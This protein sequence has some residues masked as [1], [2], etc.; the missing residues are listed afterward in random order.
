[1]GLVL[2][3][4]DGH[5]WTIK[6][7]KVEFKLFLNPKCL[8]KFISFCSAYYWCKFSDLNFLKISKINV[9]TMNVVKDGD[10]T[11]PSISFSMIPPL[12]TFTQFYFTQKI[13]SMRSS[14]RFLAIFSHIFTTSGQVSTT[15]GHS[16]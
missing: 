2:V 11:V 3:N 1:M 14:L 6:R 9:R 7:Y 16:S 10:W 8:S 4:P 15:S 5:R 12:S 13:T